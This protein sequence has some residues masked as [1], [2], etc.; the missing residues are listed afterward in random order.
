MRKIVSEVVVYAISLKI[1]NQKLWMCDNYAYVVFNSDAQFRAIFK[2]KDIVYDRLHNIQ[3]CTNNDI[4]GYDRDL[5]VDDLK[6]AKVVKITR[7]RI[8]NE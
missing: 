4:I 7:R 1:G 6:K 3:S 5:T 2:R 8:V